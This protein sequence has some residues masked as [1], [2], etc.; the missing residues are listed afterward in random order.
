MSLALFEYALLLAL[1]Y[2]FGKNKV[3]D[4]SRLSVQILEQTYISESGNKKTCEVWE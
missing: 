2:T 1:F 3:E 4:E